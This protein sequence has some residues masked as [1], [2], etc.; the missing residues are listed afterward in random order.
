MMLTDIFIDHV[1]SYSNHSDNPLHS[2]DQVTFLA[3]WKN[4]QRDVKTETF[5]KKLN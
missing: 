2:I 3:I 5:Q 1:H 4:K